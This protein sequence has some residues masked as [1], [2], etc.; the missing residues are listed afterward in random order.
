[1][2]ETRQ[3]DAFVQHLGN[4]TN[5]PVLLQA[6]LLGSKDKGPKYVKQIG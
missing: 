5:W 4:M 2:V 3:G 1:M 6:S